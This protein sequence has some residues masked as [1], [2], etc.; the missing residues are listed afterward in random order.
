MTSHSRLHATADMCNALC[1]EKIVLR[2]SITA[3]ENEK[4]CRGELAAATAQG[5]QQ[6]PSQLLLH[7]CDALA[8]PLNE[9]RGV[10]DI[11]AQG[12]QSA[13]AGQAP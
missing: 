3:S 10:A 12:R 6:E 11:P 13:H 4:T 8:L 1:A 5:G 7:R 2:Q 9:E